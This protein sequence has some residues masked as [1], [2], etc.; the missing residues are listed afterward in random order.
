MRRKEDK[1]KSTTPVNFWQSYSDI[2]AALL[3]VFVLV[4]TATLYHA[5][6]NYEEQRE[7]I[8]AQAAEL[9][10]IIGIK[11]RIIE[12]LKKNFQDTALTIDSSTG[13]VMFDS[14]LLFDYNESVL[15]DEGKEFIEDFFP[16]YMDILLS[17][18][19]A[20]YVSEIIIEGHTDDQ[21]PY[22][23]NLKLSQDRA[24][25]VAEYCLSDSQ[26]FF[27]E[28]RLQ[29]MRSII[30]ANGRSWS[31]LIY[32]DDGTVNADASRRVE[33]QFRLNDKEMI[34]EMMK[35]LRGEE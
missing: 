33:I 23:Y 2:M 13:A 8:E 6:K 30:T 1:K 25:A 4:L 34:D 32:N 20:E 28:E 16:K 10:K 22:M 27:S 7:T 24:F 12:E 11:Q 29:I 17:E 31:E 5:Q 18:N 21:G 15:K 3:L 35:A 26:E 14:Q 19:F 9:E